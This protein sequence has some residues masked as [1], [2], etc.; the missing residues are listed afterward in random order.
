MSICINDATIV[1]KKYGQFTN[2]VLR[3]SSAVH[4]RNRGLWTGEKE[5]ERIERLRE[6][7]GQREFAEDPWSASQHQ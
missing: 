4:T 7:E 3:M 1:K 5:R 2:V 6:R